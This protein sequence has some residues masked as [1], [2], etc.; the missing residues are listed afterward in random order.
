MSASYKIL[1][2]DPVSDTRKQRDSQDLNIEFKSITLGVEKR[3]IESTANGINFGSNELFSSAT[4]TSDHSLV[5]KAFVMAIAQGLDPKAACRVATTA[6]LAGFMY[7]NGQGTLTAPTNGVLN[8]DGVTNLKVGD[9][10]LVQRNT[11]KNENGIYDVL[12]PGAAAAAAVLKRSGDANSS[13]K[14]TSGLYTFVTEGTQNRTK[15]YILVTEDPITLGTTELQFEL[16][17]QG[18]AVAG[19]GIKI[20]GFVISTDYTKVIQNLSGQSVV[21]GQA[22]AIDQ[23][24]AYTSLAIATDVDLHR[25]DIGIAAESAANTENKFVIIRPGAI[26]TVGGGL[27]AGRKVYVS[28]TVPGGYTQDLSTF[29]AGDHLYSVGIAKSATEFIYLPGG[30]ELTF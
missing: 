10:V 26:V 23:D 29:T 3:L 20:D 17:N 24:N 21:Y 4:P 15:G 8:I 22:V 6:P 28:R 16:F 30:Y 19:D 27:I 2:W 7:D 9:R 13:A 1:T 11:N 18:T 14:V 25:K 5:N 12:N